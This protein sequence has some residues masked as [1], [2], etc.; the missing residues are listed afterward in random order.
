MAMGTPT[1]LR[2]TADHIIEFV[3]NS[4]K[5]MNI[6][7]EV[8]DFLI[9]SVGYAETV[10]KK[11]TDEF[12]NLTIRVSLLLSEIVVE[13]VSKILTRMGN[14]GKDFRVP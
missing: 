1:C 6:F 5:I 2:A 7:Q 13:F 3:D 11:I 4:G 9:R 10:M 8:G 14:F 12:L